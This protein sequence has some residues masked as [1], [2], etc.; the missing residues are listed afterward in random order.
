MNLGLITMAIIEGIMIGDFLQRKG[1]M[2]KIKA[3]AKGWKEKGE[4]AL[5]RASEKMDKK[6]ED[7]I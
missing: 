4:D 3:K 6:E 2:D 5:K 7:L 1:Y